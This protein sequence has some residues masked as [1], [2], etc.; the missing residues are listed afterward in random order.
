MYDWKR[1]DSARSSFVTCQPVARERD[2]YLHTYVLTFEELES[3]P[4]N[5]RTGSIRT[6]DVCGTAFAV[7]EMHLQ[8]PLLKSKLQNAPWHDIRP[9]FARIQVLYSVPAFC[10]DAG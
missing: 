10:Q 8:C 9:N 1:L 5:L 7:D 6:R 3:R 2:E 4:L